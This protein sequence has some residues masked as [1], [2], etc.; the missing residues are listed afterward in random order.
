VHSK[1]GLCGGDGFGRILADDDDLSCLDPRAV[2]LDGPL[3]RGPGQAPIPIRCDSRI[4]RDQSLVL[5]ARV[6]HMRHQD[7]GDGEALCRDEVAVGEPALQIRQHP[8]HPAD[9]ELAV[10]A[11]TA[12]RSPVEHQQAEQRRLDRVHRGEAP[13]HHLRLAGA[14]AGDQAAGLLRQVEKDGGGFGQHQ[15]VVVDRRDLFE[16]AEPAIGF[17]VQV[18]SGVVHAG[19]LERQ[20]HLFKRPQHA[21]VARV[22]ARDSVDL[23]KA[24]EL[25]HGDVPSLKAPDEMASSRA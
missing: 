3:P 21:Q 17:G 18:V 7:I 14:V 15:P 20:L 10:L 22:A 9:Q 16:R 25:E 19:Q 8:V 11:A 23:R 13:A 5:D 1:L 2:R 12:I 4:R 24:I 6:E